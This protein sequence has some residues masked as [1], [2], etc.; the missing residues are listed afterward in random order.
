MVALICFVNCAQK[1][2][3]DFSHL[4]LYFVNHSHGRRL[5]GTYAE[6]LNIIRCAILNETYFI[7]YLIL[8]VIIDF[9]KLLQNM[10][11]INVLQ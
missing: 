11:D 8:Y 1:V 2:H 7:L 3:F 6:V 4:C 10:K 5:Y 9:F